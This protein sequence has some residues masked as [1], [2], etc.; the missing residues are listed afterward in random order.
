[1]YFPG[2]PIQGPLLA[3]VLAVAMFVPGGWAALL[4]ARRF[5][6]DHAEAAAFAFCAT[7]AVGG[8]ASGIAWL[9]G[10]GLAFVAVALVAGS[11]A[12]VALFIF[13]GSHARSAPGGWPGVGLAVAAGFLSIFQG[14]Q[15]S[16][17]AD[18]F[19]HLAAIRSLLV[20]GQPIV[21][22]PF[23][24][25]TTR[26]LDPSTGAYHSVAAAFA[27]MTHLDPMDLLPALTVAGT[28]VLILSL[29][30]LFRRVSG[31]KIVPAIIVVAFAGIVLDFDFKSGAYPNVFSLGMCLLALVLLSRL[32]VSRSRTLIAAAA[33]AGFATIITHP[34]SAELYTIGVFS[35]LGWLVL[36]LVVHRFRGD[37]TGDVQRLA[38]VAVAAAFAG[39]LALPFMLP[40][41][42]VLAHTSSMEAQPEQALRLAY[43]TAFGHRFVVLDLSMFQPALLLVDIP[44]LVLAAVLLMR[45]HDFRAYL[46]LSI[47]WLR[48]FMFANPLVLGMLVAY[49]PYM[50]VRLALLVVYAPFCILAWGFQAARDRELKWVTVALAA[51]LAISAV[52]AAPD[53]WRI[54]TGPTSDAS[55]MAF[56]RVTDV[57]TEWG[58]DGLTHLRKALGTGRPV[59]AGLPN[60]QL[61]VAGIMNV[62]V[63]AVPRAQS[64]AYFQQQPDMPTKQQDMY[65]LVSPDTSE[66]RRDAIVHKYGAQYVVVDAEHVRSTSDA[67]T[68][69]L[70]DTANFRL[71]METHGLFVLAV[72]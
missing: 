6:L 9:T 62:K 55:T 65:D 57:R 10:L 42:G 72:I 37:A 12:T 5:P 46:A 20:S 64:P 67:V 3:I 13:H 24:G 27:L 7:I 60:T 70:G 61:Q 63:I 32:S 21:T 41:L 52:V 47:G 39:L 31:S 66:Q 30:S 43:L 22:D 28:G 69:M 8:L 54:W 11:L 15:L 29:W 14:Q 18:Q 45:R 40:R 16:G 50:T 53:V 33:F 17:T 58:P 68:E 4:A 35:L 25:T 1:M 2:D 23:F 51:A 44:L 49:S 56:R 36:E 26:V 19:Y 59:I 48:L 38:R 34:G 71:E